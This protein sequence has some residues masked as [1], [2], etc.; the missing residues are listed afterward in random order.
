MYNYPEYEKYANKLRMS[1]G[2]LGIDKDPIETDKGWYFIPNF[3]RYRI[4]KDYRL[5]D[6]FTGEEVS[7][8]DNLNDYPIVYVARDDR[9]RIIKKKCDFHRLVALAF[10]SVPTEEFGERIEVDHVDGTRTNYNVENLEWVTKTENYMRGRVVSRSKKKG[11]IYRVINRFKGNDSLVDTL[12]IACELSSADIDKAKHDINLCGQYRN[13]DGWTIIQINV[14]ED[15]GYRN[16]VY[17]WDYVDGSAFICRSV[18]DAIN[19]TNVSK[20]GIETSLKSS[21][22]PEC[23]YI[24]G[25]KFFYV[26]N[27]PDEFE[28]VSV[29][30]A[31]FWSY[32]RL[33]YANS[34][35]T[36][37]GY[38][39]HDTV[40]NKAYAAMSAADIMTR[41]SSVTKKEIIAASK[42]GAPIKGLKFYPIYQLRPDGSTRKL[43]PFTT[44]EYNE[45]SRTFSGEYVLSNDFIR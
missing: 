23:M 9:G 36:T 5:L 45:F 4:S 12:E 18:S 32:I 8:T 7:I 41:V 22:L 20:S 34:G 40:A 10:L 33:Y 29:G 27:T 1:N 30:E 17:V 42:L 25:Y 19:M 38:I 43:V 21:L 31:L 24:K 2:T 35:A 39:I 13:D 15:N 37:T 14:E 11:I 28:K 16:P 44:D 6:T 26:G 3:S